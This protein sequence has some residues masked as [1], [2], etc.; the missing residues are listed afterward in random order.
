MARVLGN[1]M[2]KGIC[3]VARDDLCKGDDTKEECIANWERILT[4]LNK[5]NLKL[6]PR[7]V[8]VLLQ[9]T[10]VFGHRVK[11]GK[12]RPSDHIVTSL[13]RTTREELK[14]VRQVNS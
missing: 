6:S 8:R 14:T 13:G 7:K 10:E 4:K 11:D 9:D 2:T 3:V 12:V 1:E 5:N